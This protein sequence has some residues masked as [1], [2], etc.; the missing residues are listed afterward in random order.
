MRSFF[1]LLILIFSYFTFQASAT[2]IGNTC[3]ISGDSTVC[4]NDVQTYS[5]GYAGSFQ[6]TWGAFGG[7]IV[8]GNTNPTVT[9][10]W[11]FV[12]TGQVT[13]IIKDSANAVLCTKVMNVVINPTP[14]P[15]IIPSFSAS[16]IPDT[17]KQSPGGEP[18]HR[19]ECNIVCDSTWV[20]YTTAL[21]AGSSYTWTILGSTTYTT[22]GNI[23]NVYWDAVGIGTVKVV[24]IS[25]DS[26]VGEHEIC[27]EV[28]PSPTA[29]FSTIPNATLGIINICL[30]QNVFFDNNSIDNG[31]SPL[32][33]YEW[34]FGDGNSQLVMA[35]NSGDVNHTYTTAGTYTATL[36]VTNECGCKDTT[37]VIVVVDSSPGPDIFCV[38]T[39]CP[40]SAVTY[41]TS[42]VCST[43]S[44]T[45]TN[46]TIIGVDS[47]QSVTIQWSGTSPAVV[48]LTVPCGSFCPSPTTLVVPVIPAVASYSGDTVICENECTEF[49]LECSVPVDSIIWHI[50][51]GITVTT[52]TV[53]VHKIE[54]CGYSGPVSGTIWVEYFH[55]TNGSINDLECGGNVFIPIHV[56]PKFYMSGANQYC[57]NAAFAFYIFSSATGNIQWNIENS[58][59]TSVSSTI[60]P[61]TSPFTGAW[62]W[63]AGTFVVTATDAAGSFCNNSERIIVTVSPSPPK[64][65]I[66]GAD[67]VCPNSSHSYTGIL[68]NSQN[69]LDW[70]VVGGSPAT[71]I[72]NS[73]NI[74]WN[75]TGP[76]S[77]SAYEVD[78]VTGCKSDSTTFI[79]NNYLPL[80]P[81]V[82]L[83]PD[84]VCSNGYVNYSTTSPG[85]NYEWSINPTIAGSVSTGQYSNAIQIQWNNYTG[86]AWVVLERTLCNQGRKDSVLVYVTPPPSP[87]ISAPATI[88]EDA[89][90]T[91][92]TSAIA[93]TYAWDL[94]DGNNATGSTITHTYTS[95]GSYTI[96]LTVNY[97][98]SCPVSVSTTAVIAVNPAPTV[99][100]STADPTMYCDTPPPTISTTMT[101]A[102][103][104]GTTGCNWYKSP[105]A[106]SLST[107]SSYTATLAGTY[108]AICV[109][110]LGCT[111]T[112]NPIT[113]DS[114]PCDTC[115]PEAFSLDFMK[116]NNGCNYDSFVYSSFNVTDHGWNF[117]DSYNPGT[118]SA[119]GNNVTHTYTE[120]G[121]YNIELCG[122]VPNRFNSSDTCVVCISKPDTINYVPNFFESINCTNY[123]SSFTV[124]FT[125]TTKVFALAP[126]PS[127]NWYINGGSSVSTA[128]N[129]T[130]TLAPGTY[131]I[132]L[133]INGICSI[134]KSITIVGPTSATF[135]ASDS[136]CVGAPIL[137][138]NTSSPILGSSWD[139]GDGAS[140]LLT[141]PLRS[142]SSG[143]SFNV[144]LT[145][146]NQYGC[147]D[148]M[149]QLVEVLPNTLTGYLSLS[150]PDSF[151]VGDS[152][153]ILANVSGGYS[154]YTYLWTTTA[155]TP[156]IT[157]KFTGNYGVDLYDSKGCFY[158]VPDT[159]IL[160]NPIPNPTISGKASWCQNE[161]NI[162]YVASPYPGNTFAYTVDG[163]FQ[164]SFFGNTF[165]YN[166][167]VLG[168]HWISVEVTS[169]FGCKAYDTFYFYV[170][171]NPNVTI[172]S[173]GSMCAGDSNILVGTS[174]STNLTDMYWN[175]GLQND[176]LIT[177]IPN[178]YNV[179]VIDSNGC[180]ASDQDVV[181]RLPD[182]CGLLV[183]C[184]DICD[185]VTS[186]VWYA[187]PGY[188][189]YQWYYNGSPIAW[190]TSDT[191]NVPL[192]QSGSYTVEITNASGCVIESDPIDISFVP[193]G[194]CEVDAHAD[195]D[196]GPID[197]HGNQTYTLT[198]YINNTLSSGAN[199]AITSTEGTISGL[200]AS[201]LALGANTLTATFTDNPP[202][203]SIVCF[204]ISIWDSTDRCD[205]T[206]C[207][208]TP[209]CKS[210]DC[211]LEF[212]SQQPFNCVGYDGSGNPQYY[213]CITVVWGGTNGAQLTL[214][215]PNS[216][217][218]PNPFTLNTGSNTI[219]FTYTDF[220]PLDPSG[221][222]I[223]GYVYD[224]T[225]KTNCCDSF[226]IQYKP[227]GE[228]CQMAIN[229]QCAHCEEEDLPGLWTYSIQ[230]DIN[231]PMGA[232]ANVQILPIAEGVFGTI[233][234]NP[235]PPGTTSVTVLFTDT[236]TPDSVICFKVVLTNTITHDVCYRFICISLPPCENVSVSDLNLNAAVNIYPNPTREVVT[237]ELNAASQYF[238][239]LEIED[240]NG[241]IVRLIP[242]KVRTQDKSLDVRDLEA[243]IY[244]IRI[245]LDNGTFLT[246]RLLIH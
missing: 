131:N 179:T 83:G 91:A 46:G 167:A 9:I 191:F 111:G 105:S 94:G 99:N 235:I 169:D 81:S 90:F 206:I 73:I 195:I 114:I 23:A 60:S 199:V 64:P 230:M 82:I 85:S 228:D 153:N 162:F 19:D 15:E 77:V 156:S 217:F 229:G 139:F 92:S 67:S 20:T 87:A 26:C 135:T 88:C 171:P 10:N 30:N 21:N 132:T 107:S 24:E 232:S 17:S 75:S 2:T 155:A 173:T 76:Y 41:S 220:P 78:N 236:G 240:V 53:N 126:S 182:L 95:A 185:T 56:R 45:A 211:E 128:T 98:G 96:T 129:L 148:S 188:T 74:T 71:G 47:N 163:T 127:Y 28:L 58:A 225:N 246:Q 57:E 120:P 22:S 122:R 146:T 51:A 39:V 50:P 194:G 242:L 209:P 214:S 141:S 125:N 168:A 157:A 166:G 237:I 210:D 226:R 70:V 72:G 5:S 181:H 205:T 187:P 159:V 54:V 176:T 52:D 203:D 4:E 186:L 233:T 113:I 18:D 42:A 243:G 197:H 165:G 62:Y 119:S 79:V 184:Y 6:Y 89:A 32:F 25:A 190:A 218:V 143:G 142:Y 189:K 196:C 200:T 175:T 213:G 68:S 231:N 8:G 215:A 178:I 93:S 59:G 27:I 7:T 130:T 145:I 112:S 222:L 144:T 49:V 212:V 35:P 138:N 55:S 160:V 121:I 69:S 80:T 37:S 150:G 201:T 43:Y 147:L 1:T 204:L 40:G 115:S 208:R 104:V 13:V 12:G 183:G 202:V 241:K 151:C 31:G 38:S 117:G 193:C 36:I 192:Y 137:F 118:N 14:T 61:S 198:F 44:W 177:Q 33:S 180:T 207:L 109:N 86:N 216:G 170:H 149:Q 158:K 174:T 244:L 97:G 172:L 152:V 161:F 133:E 116:Y 84:T 221:K 227:C 108:Y 219:C 140:S 224:T 106:T 34:D 16:C 101:I 3:T 11:G 48:S 223:Y 65:T 100:I 63:G 164:G 123:S 239:Q 110:A 238:T 103:S 66:V 134:T 234:P 154:P 245:K 124:T 136:V 29:L 102:A